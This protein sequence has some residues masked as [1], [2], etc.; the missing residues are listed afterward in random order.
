MTYKQDVDSYI[1]ACS[2]VPLKKRACTAEL[3]SLRERLADL[4]SVIGTGRQARLHGEKV[5][6]GDIRICELRIEYVENLRKSL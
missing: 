1:A 5:D 2:T 3:R 4:K 6:T